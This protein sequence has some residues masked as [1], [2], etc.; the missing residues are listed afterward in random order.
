[1][2]WK[3]FNFSYATSIFIQ[4]KLTYVGAFLTIHFFLFSD[5]DLFL[6]KRPFKHTKV[7]FGPQGRSKRPFWRLQPIL[8]PEEDEDDGKYS[9]MEDRTSNLLT[10]LIDSDS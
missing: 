10:C 9:E 2:T 5:N 4:Y 1:M 8:E 6:N 7:T 3:V